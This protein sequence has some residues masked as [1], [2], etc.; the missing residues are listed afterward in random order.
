MQDWLEFV[1]VLA[2]AV[3]ATGAAA[4]LLAFSSWL[5]YRY[6]QG[7]FVSDV[8]HGR[9]LARTEALEA[10]LT[11]ERD[12]HQ[13]TRETLHETAD[14]LREAVTQNGMLIQAAA[15]STE[16]MKRIDQRGQEGGRQ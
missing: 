15:I 6:A 12:A 11:K 1:K 14:T 10:Q 8:E 13:V 4:I 2:P 9:A 3:P 7:K 16:V 5:L